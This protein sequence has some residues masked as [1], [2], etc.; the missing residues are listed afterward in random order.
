[1]KYP[2]G[3]QDFESL[4]KE[5]YVYVDKT[6]F[7]YQIANSGRYYFLS[8]PRRFGKSLLV[9]TLEAYFTGKKELF[10]GLAIEKLEKEWTAYPVLHLDLNARNYETPDDLLKILNLTLNQWEKEYG[11]SPDED[12][13]DARFLGIIRRANEKTGKQAIILIDEYDKPLLEAINNKELTEAYRSTLDAFYSVMKTQD[14]LIKFGF[15]TGVTHF[16]KV[17][18]FSGLNNLEDISVSKAYAGI[19]GITEGEL[20]NY[21]GESVAALAS[22][23]NMTD[24]EC[25]AK[26]RLMYDG[27]HF[28]QDAVGVY[29]PFSLFRAF[30]SGE[31]GS[32]WFETGTPSFLTKVIQKADYSIANLQRE[33]ITADILGQI[34]NPSGTPIPLLYQTG[35]LTLKSYDSETGK[36]QFTFPNKE[37][38]RGFIEYLLPSY[39]RENDDIGDSYVD[40]FVQEVRRGDPEAFLSRMQAMLADSDYQIMGRME[41]YF[42]NVMFIIFRMMGFYTQV[43]RHTAIGRIDLIIQTSDYI[44]LIEVKRDGSADEALRQIEEKGYAAPFAHDKRRLFKIG[45]NFS[46]ETRGIAEWKMA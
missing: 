34:D 40:S 36:Y 9:S 22:E 38:E 26:L 15:L 11:S 7:I 45:V 24:D 12:S 27:Y 8:R 16:A 21:F 30:K 17:S 35:Y 43:E 28:H 5:G 3:I 19:C 23:N 41:I 14:G 25:Y 18:I 32:Y 1:M 42:Q 20:H 37:V 13:P 2:I 10:E 6:A 44:Y 46:S 29:N 33:K 39:L 31:F 4:R